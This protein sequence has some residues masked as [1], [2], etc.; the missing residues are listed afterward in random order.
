[1]NIY[2]ISLAIQPDLPV[3]PGDPAILN[4]RIAKMEEGSPVNVTHISMGAH[5]G[6]HVDAPY[7]F[8][9]GDA[10]RIE[11][12]SL[13]AMIGR[14]HMVEVP[15]EISLITADVLSQ[16]DISRRARRLLFKTRNSKLWLNGVR[17][18]QPDFVALSASG[19]QFLV[20]KGIALVGIDY[21]SIATYDDWIPTHRILLEA[22]IVILEGLD[23]SVVPPGR[24]SLCCLPIN[25]AGADGAPARAIL[26]GA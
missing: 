9:G 3:W 5:V 19:A 2:D 1:M 4:S 18:F 11:A 20:D 14:A 16:V 24:Y 6:T 12:L 22:G 17:E 10:P 23:L 21:L 25:L 15:D 26:I 7:H 8:L 13:N